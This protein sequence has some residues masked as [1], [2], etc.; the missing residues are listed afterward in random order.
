MKYSWKFNFFSQKISL[1]KKSKNLKVSE[2]SII[3][4][5]ATRGA[6]VKSNQIIT[7]LKIVTQTI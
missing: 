4:V 5:K 6:V 1:E 3:N 2:I 7:R